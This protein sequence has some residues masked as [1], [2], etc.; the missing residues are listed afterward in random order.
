M[1][2]RVLLLVSRTIQYKQTSLMY[3]SFKVTKYDALSVA[4]LSG[5]IRPCC[6]GPEQ[7][8]ELEVSFSGEMEKVQNHPGEK[9]QANATTALQT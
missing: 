4:F 5:I 1:T 2:A 7:P 6:F 3:S 9:W 8:V